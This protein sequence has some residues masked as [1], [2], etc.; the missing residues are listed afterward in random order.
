MK[1][2]KLPH[3]FRDTDLADRI[4]I[5]V[6]ENGGHFVIRRHYVEFY[7]PKE[8]ELFVRLM[9]PALEEERNYELV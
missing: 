3:A 8:Y 2:F 6:Q 9:C 1:V 4:S 5:Y 7:I